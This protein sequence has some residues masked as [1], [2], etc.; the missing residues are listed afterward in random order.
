M[1]A[2]FQ[3]T[4]G[5]KREGKMQIR[6]LLNNRSLEKI[7][8]RLESDLDS[9]YPIPFNQKMIL[10][11]SRGW[12][13]KRPSSFLIG[14]AT[15]DGTWPS[16]SLV[17]YWR[18]PNNRSLWSFLNAPTPDVL[19]I[20]TLCPPRYHCFFQVTLPPSSKASVSSVIE[21]P[22]IVT[23]WDTV[24]AIMTY[25]QIVVAGSRPNNGQ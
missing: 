17:S 6:K 1:I 7:R 20:W 4:R 24:M 10:Y 21:A 18:G 13:T 3:P 9:R 23:R 8:F 19:H 2:L 5:V 14:R 15:K 12:S 11:N 25:R 22:S 16:D